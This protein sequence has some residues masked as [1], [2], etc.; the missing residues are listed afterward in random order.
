M[1]FLE[2]AN[3]PPDRALNQSVAPLI[4]GPAGELHLDPS[5]AR[6]TGMNYR[7]YAKKQLWDMTPNFL[8]ARAMPLTVLDPGAVAL[9]C[10]QRPGVCCPTRATTSR[11]FR[12]VRGGI[13]CASCHGDPSRHLAE[14]GKGPILNPSQPVSGPARFHLSRM[15]PGRRS[16]RREGEAL[17]AFQRATI[18]STRPCISKTRAK[19]SGGPRHQPVGIAAGERMQTREQRSAHLHHVS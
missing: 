13:S 15:P 8:D 14:H 16:H 19:R 9:P 3:A 10:Q 6:A 17:G 18:S 11:G 7:L 1:A 4:S 12:F 2:R 5:S